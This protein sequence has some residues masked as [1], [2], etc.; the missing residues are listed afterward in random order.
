[1]GDVSDE[2]LQKILY[3]VKYYYTS[4]SLQKAIFA[5]TRRKNISLVR[6]K[7]FSS[8]PVKILRYKHPKAISQFYD[9]YLH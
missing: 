7:E 9:K 1:M 8:V 4:H 5:G 2:N 6:E 3:V